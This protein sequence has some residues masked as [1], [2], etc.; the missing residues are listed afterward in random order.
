MREDHILVAWHSPPKESSCFSNFSFVDLA[1][2]FLT[3]DH[4]ML[5]SLHVDFNKYFIILTIF[6]YLEGRSK[7]PPLIPAKTLAFD[8]YSKTC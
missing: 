5:T 2:C 7:T 1:N 8:K 4:I 6:E 3:K